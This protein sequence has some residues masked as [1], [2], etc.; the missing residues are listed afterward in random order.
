ML[1]NWLISVLSSPSLSGV[2]S[3]LVKGAKF[4]AYVGEI[5]CIEPTHKKLT[6]LA[7]APEICHYATGE[8]F[9][10]LSL[11]MMM[12]SNVV[13]DIYKYCEWNIKVVKS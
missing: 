10:V 5:D 11:I 3:A 7:R 2:I 8:M 12:D 13:F 1:K 6:G 9:S 4:F